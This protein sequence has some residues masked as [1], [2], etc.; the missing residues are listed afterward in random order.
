MTGGRVT[1]Q[2]VACGAVLATPTPAPCHAHRHTLLQENRL[3]QKRIDATLGADLLGRVAFYG[4]SDITALLEVGGWVGWVGAWRA[5]S[6]AAQAL[7][8][9]GPTCA[10]PRIPSNRSP[11][12]P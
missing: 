5:R 7:D 1:A 8:V 10:A 2:P 9:R 3:T 4:Q 12:A 6:S 11:T